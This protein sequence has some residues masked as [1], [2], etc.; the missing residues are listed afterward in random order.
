MIAL[1]LG[2]IGTILTAVPVWRVGNKLVTIIV[3][4]T[5]PAT[6]HDEAVRSANRETALAL[7]RSSRFNFAIFFIGIGFVLA[8]QLV[9]FALGASEP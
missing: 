9:G 4:L 2:L 7:R 5:D 8:S 1:L 6:V 3:L